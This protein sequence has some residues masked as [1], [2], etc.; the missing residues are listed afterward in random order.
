[1]KLIILKNNLLEGLFSVER[2]VS[3]NINLPILKNILF[4]TENNKIR[5]T[6]TNLELATT[7]HLSGKIIEEGKT[8]VPFSI[9]YNI[10][11][12]LN[13]ERIQL[14]KKDN[15]LNIKTDNYEAVIYGQNHE[16]FPIIPTVTSSQPAIVFKNAA[17]KDAVSKVIIAAQYSEI[18]PEIS[19][20]LIKH[21][22]NFLKL[23]ATDSFRLAEE[24]LP[25]D[26][27]QLKTKDIELIVPLKT[28]QELLRIV[29]NEDSDIR[30]F[31]DANQ[32]LFKTE[33][34]EIIS[35]IIDGQFP[36][37]EAIIP[38]EIKHEADVNRQEL[39]N[40]VKLTSVFTSRANDIVIRIGENKK[41]LEVFAAESQLGENRYLVPIKLRGD[42]FSVVFNWR[43]LL[44]G[45]KIHKTEE[46]VLGVNGSDKPAVIKSA[47][48]RS[49]F[50][51]L[52][53]IKS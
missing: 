6:A 45:L 23:V 21:K 44:D 1:M 36:D 35:R 12:N 43:Y 9:F 25:S 28:A 24:T 38:K 49:I 20:I 31:V 48:D 3:E 2:S 37:Y 10:I 8:C 52:M 42:K 39:I 51:V 22:D 17:F 53:P 4:I 32:V 46:I 13:T 26:V 34:Q 18:R 30:M 11:R 40:A 33:N 15:N 7:H 47:E 41:F 5:I 29:N 14:E 19:G 16:D 27:Y 50:Y